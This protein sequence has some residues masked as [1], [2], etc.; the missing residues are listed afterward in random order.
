MAKDQ[1]RMYR[2]PKF[3]ELLIDIRAEMA[4]EADYDVDL[5][6]QM[7]RSGDKGVVK[8]HSMTGPTDETASKDVRSRRA[9]RR[10]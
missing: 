8:E 1:E 10:K 4:R 5:L 9:G 7:V 6:V 2:R 3:L